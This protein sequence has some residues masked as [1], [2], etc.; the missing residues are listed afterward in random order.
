MAGDQTPARPG[1]DTF[2]KRW[3]DTEDWRVPQRPLDLQRFEGIRRAARSA[4]EDDARK[5]GESAT[6][7]RGQHCTKT[8]DEPTQRRVR[9]S[10]PTRRMRPHPPEVFLV[11]KLHSVSGYFNSAAENPRGRS[12]KYAGPSTS[13][14]KP[15]NSQRAINKEVLETV[16]A[17]SQ[18]AQAA[19]AWMEL[20][21]DIDRRAVQDFAESLLKLHGRSLQG[22]PPEKSYISQALSKHIK[23]DCIVP[24]NQWLR[25]AGNKETMALESLLKTLSTAL[26]GAQHAGLYS[27][28]SLGGKPWK[29][30][31]AEYQIHPEWV[32]QPWHTEYH[33]S[34]Q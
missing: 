32:T 25:R 23:P 3:V 28:D 30:R 29:Q 24:M 21:P 19:K 17:N 27:H 1:R 11:T 8:L 18:L 16:F 6:T 15:R 33:Y 4:W 26:L 2:R 13:C 14:R 5:W 34:A 10:S 31:I 7:Y 22:G 20:A 12:N 9:P